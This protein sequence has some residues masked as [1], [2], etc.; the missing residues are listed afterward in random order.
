MMAVGVAQWCLD[1]D[2]VRAIH[3][4]AGFGLR[5]IHLKI[6]RPSDAAGLANPAIRRACLEA[7]R[8]AGVR[9]TALAVKMV[10]FAGY[11]G[12]MLRGLDLRPMPFIVSFAAYFI[13]LHTIEAT[14]LRR[15]VMNDLRSPTSERA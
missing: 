10:F 8:Q 5:V 7:A 12:V 13:A 3:L 9:I 14:F 4:A 6:G 2:P 15:L 1:A 11:V